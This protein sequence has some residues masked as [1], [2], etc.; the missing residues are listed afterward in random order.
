[1]GILAGLN[2][3]GERVSLGSAIERL[4]VVSAIDRAGRVTG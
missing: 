4:P 3:L 1:V 2:L